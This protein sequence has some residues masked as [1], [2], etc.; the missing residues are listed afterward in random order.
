VPTKLVHTASSLV[1]YD[2][3]GSIGDSGV[4]GN[5]D[6]DGG[7]LSADFTANPVSGNAPLTVNFIDNSTGN[8]AFWLWNFG[9]GNTSTNQNPLHTYVS[10]G[11]YD[12]TLTVTNEDGIDDS[13]TKTNYIDVTEEQTP[14]FGEFI[15]D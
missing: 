11:T 6:G 8:S 1:I 2:A 12:V 4:G 15:T 14:E 9:D 10:Q 3:Y 13:I 7:D 5:G